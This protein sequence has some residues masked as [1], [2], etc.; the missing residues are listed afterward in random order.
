MLDVR[1]ILLKTLGRVAFL[2]G[3]SANSSIDESGLDPLLSGEFRL[4]LSPAGQ[5]LS[6]GLDVV[7][8]RC[9]PRRGLANRRRMATCSDGVRDVSIF[10]RST[11][12]PVHTLPAPHLL[13]STFGTERR[14]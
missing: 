6:L 10:T 12:P 5:R 11:R 4:T 8:N 7:W 3:N 9:H 1:Y 13:P 2:E 14:S